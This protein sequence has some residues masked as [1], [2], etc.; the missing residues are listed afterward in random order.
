MTSP[1]PRHLS[2]T[3]EGRA[4]AA[5]SARLDPTPCAPDD[6]P[7]LQWSELANQATEMM[8]ASAQVISHR[9]G[10][11]ATAG[12]APSADD[13][14][15]FSLMTQEKFEAAAESS[16]SVAAHCLQLNQQLWTQMLAQ[17]QDA[18]TAM[19]S[20]A[21]SSNL[22]ESMTHQATLITAMSPSVDA[23]TQLS[24]A[25]ADLT[26]RALDPIHARATANAERLARHKPTDAE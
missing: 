19:V 1:A 17:M 3:D 7:L 26:R 6:D 13:L 5:A 16:L 8:L 18:M 23:H 10:R 12:P 4:T 2:P 14:D 9:T 22:A 21:T 20:A 25:A 24:N 11:M 15:E